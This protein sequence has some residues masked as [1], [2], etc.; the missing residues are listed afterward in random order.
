MT[1]G[2]KG[3]SIARVGDSHLDKMWRIVFLLDC[4]ASQDKNDF[5]CAAARKATWIFPSLLRI[6]RLIECD[7]TPENAMWM[8][9]NLISL[10]QW[11]VKFARDMRNSCYLFVC[12]FEN[13]FR[14]E[15]RTKAGSQLWNQARI[16]RMLASPQFNFRIHYF[17]GQK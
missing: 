5:E 6:C 17:A 15:I 12:Y 9:F 8:R 14:R 13:L 11:T 7:R 2:S 10:R 4:T 3:W 16:N 1:L